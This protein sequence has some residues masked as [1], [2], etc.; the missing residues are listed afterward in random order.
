MGMFFFLSPRKS[1]F[2][3][4][5]HAWPLINMLHVI[6]HQKGL[7]LLSSRSP[8]LQVTIKIKLF[9]KRRNCPFISPNIPEQPTKSPLSDEALDMCWDSQLYKQYYC[10]A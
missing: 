8:Q 1:K 9:M 2:L 7:N 5:M 3:L 10:H 6:Y 4:G